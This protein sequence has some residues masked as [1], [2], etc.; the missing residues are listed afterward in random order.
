MRALTRIVDVEHVGGYTLRVTFSDGLV[1]ELAFDDT[2]ASGILASLRE[3]ELFA[4]VAI[5]PTTGT[6][7]WP[8]GIDVDPDVLHGD[9]APGAGVAP[10]VLHE[11]RLRATG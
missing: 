2:F 8:N 9:Q 6:L 3:P 7:A 5:D 1:R 11:Y 4:Q 10:V